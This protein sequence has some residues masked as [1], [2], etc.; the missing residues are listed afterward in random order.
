ML[1][2][3]PAQDFLFSVFIMLL[4]VMWSLKYLHPTFL[5]WFLN[6]CETWVDTRNMIS[7]SLSFTWV[8]DLFI[9]STFPLGQD[10]VF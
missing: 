6:Y 5:F 3:D 8:T 2:D 1:D 4:Y 7:F 9:G 10:K